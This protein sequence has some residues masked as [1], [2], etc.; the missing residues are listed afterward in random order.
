[1]PPYERSKHARRHPKTCPVRGVDFMGRKNQVYCCYECFKKAA[2]ARSRKRMKAQYSSEGQAQRRREYREGINRAARCAVAGL[3]CDQRQTLA[4]ALLSVYEGQRYYF[5]GTPASQRTS[6][7]RRERTEGGKLLQSCK[8]CGRK[9]VASTGGR[10]NV[11]C[12]P[13]CRHVAHNLQS[14]KISPTTVHNARIALLHVGTA[15]RKRL[16]AMLAEVG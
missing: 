9:F 10:N 11:Y 4:Y 16:A 7:H 13:E 3:D 1:M 12:S 15:Q 2:N 6:S 8:V 5:L 14:R